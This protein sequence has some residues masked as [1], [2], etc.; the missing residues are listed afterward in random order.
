MSPKQV[1]LT[2]LDEILAALELDGDNS[3]SDEDQVETES[4]DSDLSSQ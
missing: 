4:N 1:E 3:S 2:V